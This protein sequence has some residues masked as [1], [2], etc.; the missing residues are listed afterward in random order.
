MGECASLSSTVGDGRK[1]VFVREDPVQPGGPKVF[2]NRLQRVTKRFCN[3]ASVPE[4]V[5]RLRSAGHGTKPEW[6]ILAS[7]GAGPRS[8]VRHEGQITQ[9]KILPEAFVASE[10]KRLVFPDRTTERSAKF[11]ASKRRDIPKIKEISGVQRTISQKF[12]DIA[13]QVVR[14]RS[15]NDVYPRPGR[16][17]PYS[18]PC[19]YLTT[20]NSRTAS[21]PRSCSADSLRVCC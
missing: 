19:V 11:I 3:P 8:V 17:L 12:I 7:H 1:R 21:T 15:S 9:A 16:G 6:P 5:N 2:A 18:A 13:V 4:E 10:Q 14:A 20:E